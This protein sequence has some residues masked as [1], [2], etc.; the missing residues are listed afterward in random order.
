MHGDEDGAARLHKRKQEALKAAA[1]RFLFE[2]PPPRARVDEVESLPGIEL[3]VAG[4]YELNHRLQLRVLAHHPRVRL[5]IVQ[6][7]TPA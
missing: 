5:G 1:Q 4:F 2:L 3:A 6:Y 7:G